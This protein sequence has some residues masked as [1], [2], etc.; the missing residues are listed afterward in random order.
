MK[1]RIPVHDIVLKTLGPLATIAAVTTR[2]LLPSLHALP[3]SCQSRM[4]RSHLDMIIGGLLESVLSM[5]A[6][7]VTSVL[8]L[9]LSLT[10]PTLAFGKF[11]LVTSMYEV[12]DLATWAGKGLPVLDRIDIREQLEQGNWL[13]VFYSQD[14]PV[15]RRRSHSMN[16]W[17]AMCREVRRLSRLGYLGCRLWVHVGRYTFMC[18][19]KGGD[20]HDWIRGIVGR[21][22]NW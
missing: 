9:A 7:A 2:V 15:V 13:V 10:T 16:R 19:A 14:F 8:F 17:P 22:G 12:F 5:K 4:L 6:V 11:V 18:C 1:W 20:Y 21:V 3:R